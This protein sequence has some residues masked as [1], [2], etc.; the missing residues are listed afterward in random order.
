MPRGMIPT[1]RLVKLTLQLATL[2]KPV[3]TLW[4]P[5]GFTDNFPVREKTKEDKNPSRTDL[6]GEGQTGWER[7]HRP[8]GTN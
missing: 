7:T 2:R 8:R 3:N 6:P 1:H 4:T 5:R